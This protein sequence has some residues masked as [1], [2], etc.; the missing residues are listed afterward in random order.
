M[1]ECQALFSPAFFRTEKESTSTKSLKDEITTG[2]K[3][4][5]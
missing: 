1:F 4:T 2:W 5:N 3:K